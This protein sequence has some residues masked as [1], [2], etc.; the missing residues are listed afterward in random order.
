M[1]VLV[2]HS[3]N[4]I[5]RC[6]RPNTICSVRLGGKIISPDI[7]SKVVAFICLYL[8]VMI[9]GGVLLTA[10]GMP[11][12]SAFLTSFNCVSNTS[13]G[14]GYELI[15]AAGKWCMSLLMLIGRLEIFTVL[16]L[17]SRSFWTK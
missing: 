3:S 10:L 1:V 16:I 7:V 4:E 13:Y 2:K 12:L 11:M 15:P 5:Y 17:F 9:V 8:M 14:S 6:M